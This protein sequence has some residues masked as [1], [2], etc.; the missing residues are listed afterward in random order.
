MNWSEDLF[1]NKATLYMAR[2]SSE[3][4]EGP[5][6]AF[7][8]I[9][10]L[11]LL[12]RAALAKV[13]PVLLADPLEGGDTIFYALGYG[14]TKPP[15]SIPIRTVLARCQRVVPDFTK[16]EV[17]LCITWVNRRNEEVHTGAA[18]FEGWS[19]GL[20][21]AEFY[22]ICS[23]LVRFQGKELADL[24]GDEE[25]N[26]AKVMIGGLENEKRP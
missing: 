25:G 21:L 17:D 14:A 3:Q 1:W 23:L 8:S 22:R 6:F 18:A 12:A 4:R 13:H 20:W 5:L 16:T 7:W 26:G 11:E 19:T 9:L 10:G 24:F 2:A 15:K